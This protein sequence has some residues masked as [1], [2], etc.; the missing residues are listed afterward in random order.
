M[1]S[2]EHDPLA[3]KRPN[4]VGMPL[5][6]TPSLAPHELAPEEEQEDDFGPGSPGRRAR[7]QRYV[8]LTVAGCALLCVAAI[9]RVGIARVNAADE[10]EAS[11]ASVAHPSPAMTVTPPP[12]PTDTNA[13]AV[14]PSAE[15]AEPSSAASTA[16]TPATASAI[17]ERELARRSL[18]Q[19]CARRSRAG[20]RSGSDRCRF[21]AA[22]RIR[23]SGARTRGGRA[24]RVSIVSEVS[25]AWP[26]A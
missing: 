7:L 8:K 3:T 15:R 11:A 24:G 12:A 2:N 13:P 25:E 5:P 18:E 17:E 9:V 10:A 22:P 14:A 20:G 21:V 26:G 4:L 16:S 19:R 23:Q 6:V 1:K